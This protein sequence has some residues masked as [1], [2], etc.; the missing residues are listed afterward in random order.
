MAKITLREIDRRIEDVRSLL[1]V[2]TGRLVELDA[3]VTRQLLESSTSLRGV[4]AVTW[5]DASSR[6]AALWRAQFALEGR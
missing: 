4:T 1:D 2:T 5:A 6:H 3:D